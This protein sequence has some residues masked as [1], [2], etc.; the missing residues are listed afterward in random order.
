MTETLI[1]VSLMLASSSFS[2]DSFPT[3]RPKG[4]MDLE[5]F[6]ESGRSQ[7]EVGNRLATSV[8]EGCTIFIGSVRQI[9]RP[10]RGIPSE[11]E[12][13]V[14]AKLNLRIDEWLWNRQADLG[15]VIE[16]VQTISSEKR[17]L[18]SEG[19]SA[20]DGVEV[21][22]GARLLVALNRTQTGD[23]RYELVISDG[24]LF[25]I[26]QQALAWHT[27][28]VRE[29]NEVLNASQVV[30]GNTDSIFLSYFVS[31]L[32][33][34]GTFGNHEFEALA[35]GG[36][37]SN[38]HLSQ[39]SSAFLRLTLARFML[40]E[41]EPLSDSTRRDLMEILT[42]VGSSDDLQRAADA[43]IILLRL[44]DRKQLQMKPYLNSQ[45]QRRLNQNYRELIKEGKVKGGHAEFEQ[46][47][48][49]HSG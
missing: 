31:Y 36:L 2:M 35:L 30:I 7:Y 18:G 34:G 22:V 4:Q 46:Q 45:K 43:I 44:S 10:V 14:Q 32:Y 38:V 15:P 11:R 19:R 1:T 12:G 42:S 33:R 39:Q 20:W 5:T 40:S 37:L 3:S 28:Y 47:L 13:A 41:F 48:T 49:P 25:P 27:R 24:S 17:R 29:P 26:V 16:V 21:S 9:E 6:Q 8:I 23:Q